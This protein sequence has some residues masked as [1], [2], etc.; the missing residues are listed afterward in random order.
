MKLIVGLGNPDTKYQNTR[1]NVGF[2]AVDT[3][4]DQ[5]GLD[6]RLDK[7]FN[8][9][10][11]K[12]ADY[13]LVKPATYMNNSGQAVRKI[14][15]YY[16]LLPDKQTNDADLTAQLTV[17]H[18]DLDIALGKHKIAING[19]AAGH[20][21]VQSIINHLNTARFIRLRLGIASPALDKARHSIFPGAVARFVL[22]K[23]PDAEQKIINDTLRQALNAI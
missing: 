12:G 4:A 18:D 5:A 8:A 7:Q 13:F 14:M 16:H 1:H 9:Y 17:I 3:L 15:A 11:A 22:K 20:N 21:G 2:M 6:W 19:S 23:F 10:I